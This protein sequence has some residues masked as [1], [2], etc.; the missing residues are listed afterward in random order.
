MKVFE[1]EEYT[2]EDKYVEIMPLFFRLQHFLLIICVA[3]LSL[4]GFS[5][6]FHRTGAGELLV[7]LEGGFRARGLLHRGAAITLL[8]LA[9][10]H[11][12][13]IFFTLEGSREFEKLKI[14]GKDVQD[15]KGVIKFSL[16][17]TDTYP[18][19]PRYS[20][21][22]KFQYWGV[23]LGLLVMIITGFFL[24]FESASMQIFPKW[25]FDVV[26]ITHGYE[27]L[28]VFLILLLWHMY[29]VHLSPGNFP[30]SRT[31]ITGKADRAKLAKERPGFA[32]KS[33]EGK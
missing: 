30:M 19:L 8:L 22:E 24:W 27:G 2:D 23:N 7:S 25:V 29:N 18:A 21:K 11:I 31:W 10:Y 12:Y 33:K 15:L 16:G 5:I 4:T 28:I 9:V 6:F 26:M 20:Y 17:L 32:Y 14:R 1:F 13:Y 3:I